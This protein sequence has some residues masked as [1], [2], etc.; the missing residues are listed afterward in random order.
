MV[1]TGV[2]LKKIEFVI[3]MCKQKLNPP[4]KANGISKFVLHYVDES[5][6]YQRAGRTG[7]DCNGYYI[8]LINKKHRE[9]LVPEHMPNSFRE[10]FQVL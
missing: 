1:E 10:N 4:F 7:R 3:D 6:F 8:A 5:S 9:L 2:T